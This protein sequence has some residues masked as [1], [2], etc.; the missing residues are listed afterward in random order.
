MHNEFIEDAVL[1]AEIDGV[2]STK[3]EDRT[4]SSIFARLMSDAVGVDISKER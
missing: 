1:L 3:E 2:T 4:A